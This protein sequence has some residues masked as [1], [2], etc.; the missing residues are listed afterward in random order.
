MWLWPSMGIYTR[1][2]KISVETELRSTQV[3]LRSCY[4]DL[5][6]RK[7]WNMFNCARAEA[8]A[9]LSF[10][11]MSSGVRVRLTGRVKQCWSFSMLGLAISPGGCAM[12]TASTGFG[13]CMIHLVGRAPACWIG[14]KCRPP[15]HQFVA[16]RTGKMSF[17]WFL[18]IWSSGQTHDN[19]L[20]LLQH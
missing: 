14:K 7:I 12:R 9:E 18:R 11:S 5:I 19:L 6:Y 10:L 16:S 3:E 1:I 15:R 13:G 8:A 2:S 17:D 4:I 20:M